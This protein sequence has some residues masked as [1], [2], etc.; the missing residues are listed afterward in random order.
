[1]KQPDILTPDQYKKLRSRSVTNSKGR[2]AISERDYNAITSD[3]R[4]VVVAGG[5]KVSKTKKVAK[6]VLKRKNKY[7]AK[8][9]VYNG[10]EYDSKKEAGYAQTLDG[11]K[12]EG[13]VKDWKRQVKFPVT[14]NG[15]DCGFYKL[16]FLI[17]YTDGHK[18]YVDIKGCKKGCAYSMFRLKKKIIEAIYCIEIKEI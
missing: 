5:T 10:I 17:Q 15:H 2:L 12:T 11:L 13:K 4:T 18:E 7:S 1:M 3:L 16:D 9:T 14:V 6:N 8:K